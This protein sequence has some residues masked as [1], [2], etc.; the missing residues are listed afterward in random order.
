M[1]NKNLIIFKNTFLKSKKGKLK[2][3]KISCLNFGLIGIKALESGIINNKQID[4]FI[5]AIL[6]KTN[7]CIKFWI[8]VFPH[9]YTTKKPVGSKMGKGKGKLSHKIYK[10]TN[11][12]IIIEFCG[13]KYKN[14]INIINSIKFKLP[15]KTKIIKQFNNF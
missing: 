1:Q 6:K 3:F 9:F 8:K 7:K 14:I 11:G 4:L 5:E 15:I 10:I 2:K 12:I 13:F